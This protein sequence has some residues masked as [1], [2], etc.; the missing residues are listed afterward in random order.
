MPRI[1]PS[2][3]RDSKDQLG[4]VVL[5]IGALATLAAVMMIV[6]FKVILASL[7]I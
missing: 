3:S 6:G 1:F 2:M 4:A 7:A 5:E